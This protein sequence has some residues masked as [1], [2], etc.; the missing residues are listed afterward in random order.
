MNAPRAQRLRSPLLLTF[1]ALLAFEAGGGLV[2]F[3][4]RL[5][6]GTVPGERSHVL[7]GIP[8]A[9]FYTLYLWQH[10]R[11]VSPVRARLDYVLGLIAAG[12]LIASLALGTAL[13]W[14]W[15]NSRGSGQ[16]PHY[17]EWVSAAHNITSMLVL[18]FVLAHLL[19]VLARDRESFG[20]ARK[21]KE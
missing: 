1:A 5:A 3:Y 20:N 2:I 21:R 16:P 19:A 9:L 4:A 17:P 8:L 6:Y 15:W 12:S 7:V 13:G 11:R 14:L 10:W 18:T